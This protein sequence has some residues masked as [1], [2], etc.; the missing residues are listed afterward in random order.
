MLRD[1]DMPFAEIREIATVDEPAIA[2]R[3]IEL[4][5]ERLAERLAEQLDVLGAAERL[6]IRA[7]HTG[8]F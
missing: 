5:A 6:L 2:H 8:T 4:H 3:Y 7:M 1:V